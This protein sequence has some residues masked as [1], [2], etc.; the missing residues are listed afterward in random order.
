MWLAPTIVTTPGALSRERQTSPCVYDRGCGGRAR[1]SPRTFPSSAEVRHAGEGHD[2]VG[3]SRVFLLG[4]GEA[5]DEMVTQHASIGF[6]GTVGN[7]PHIILPKLSQALGRTIVGK[8]EFLNPGGSVKDR[9][10]R[11]IIDDAEERGVLKP[12]GTIVEG[13][14]GN[15]GIALALSGTLAATA[16]SS[17]SRT[18][19]HRRNTRSCA[20]SAPICASSKRSRSP[21]P[22]I[23]IM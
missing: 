6:S 14:A 20:R 11:G 16:A 8:A 5:T 15:T 3:R 7:T 19:S 12:G 4:L 1:H 13:T 23:I 17:A 9:A 10:A 2:R 22:A 18:I 21:I